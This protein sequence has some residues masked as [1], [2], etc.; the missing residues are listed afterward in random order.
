[1][2]FGRAFFSRIAAAIALILVLSSGTGA[3]D[4]AGDSIPQNVYWGDTHVHTSNSSDAGRYTILVGPEEAYRFARGEQVRTDW[5]TAVK[6]TQPLDFLVV[7]DHA[8]NIGLWPGLRAA[9]PLLLKDEMGRRWYGQLMGTNRKSA[10]GSKNS[11]QAKKNV[12]KSAGKPAKSTAGKVS[13]GGRM[14][15]DFIRSIWE[16]NCA[17][18]DRLNQPG[19]F[20]ALI[21]YEWTSMPG[22]NNLHRV[23]IFKDSAD[24]ATQ[25]LPFSRFDSEN[26]ED[27][28]RHMAAYEEKS[29]GN[30]LA[31]PHNGNMSNGLMFALQTFMGEPLTRDYAVIRSRWEPLVEITQLKGAAE[32]HPILS[33]NDEFADYRIWD[34]GNMGV[35]Q[36][37]KGTGA[38]Q[39]W[40]LPHE[41]TRSTLKIGLDLEDELGVNPFKFGAIGGTDTHTGLTSVWHDSPIG[42]RSVVETEIEGVQSWKRKPSRVGQTIWEQVAGGIGAVWSTE[43]T[44]K[45]L[46][47]AMERKETY[48][49]TGPRVTVRFFGGWDYVAEDAASRDLAKT[50]YEKGVP[51]G[52]DLTRAP[53]GKSPTF[54]IRAV[55]DPDGANLDRLQVI[56]GWR[57]KEDGLLEKV[58]NV[59]LSDGRTV[60]HNGKA[61]PVGNTVDVANG[62]YT[63]SIGEVELSVVWKDPDFDRGELAFYYARVLEI[64]TPRW[65]DFDKL[66]VESTEGF[67]M[68][69]AE[70]AYTSPIWYTP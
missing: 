64:P 14:G 35:K 67:P 1:M 49:T 8:E 15:D 31:I 28:W 3:Q 47:E 69:I 59:A 63:N 45:G 41:Y 12:T 53:D 54:I 5:G 36:G 61:E 21:G 33:P 11:P 50:G 37:A 57:D 52:G 4:A 29:G 9:D 39:A 24:R 20:T 27:L 70:R 2:P 43:N 58:Y 13:S 19:V 10:K 51:M 18:A 17:T 16:R 30:I 22:G 7:A 48:A 46:F 6:L 44:R 56:K 38:K 23:A 65:T 62:F 68:T 42:K 66:E 40:M 26:P 32:A 55:K 25:V 60:D 34:Q